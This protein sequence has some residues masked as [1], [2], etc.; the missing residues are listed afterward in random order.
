MFHIN[1]LNKI[2]A[3]ENVFAQVRVITSGYLLDEG[4][5]RKAAIVKLRVETL[6]QFQMLQCQVTQNGYQNKYYSDKVFDL[7]LHF[8]LTLKKSLINL[9]SMYDIVDDLRP[10]L[11]IYLLRQ[12]LIVL[13]NLEIGYMEQ[14]KIDIGDRL[15]ILGVNK[16][17]MNYYYST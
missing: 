9:K 6:I 1:N 8:E 10:I 17:S 5:N 15:L 11:V 14:S 16:H 2:D 12:S 3:S 7:N 13:S 4:G